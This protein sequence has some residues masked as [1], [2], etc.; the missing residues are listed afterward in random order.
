MAN[1][2]GMVLP[3]QL[4]ALSQM[5]AMAGG[6]AGQGVPPQLAQMLGQMQA[7][8][9]NPAGLAGNLMQMMAGAQQPMMAAP[10][11]TV[12]AV[13][14]Q[15]QAAPTI[16]QAAPSSATADSPSR[17]RLA[18]VSPK[19]VSNAVKMTGYA[20]KEGQKV[21]NWKK[22]YFKLTE[23][24][25][26]YHVAPGSPAK[27]HIYLKSVEDRARDLQC[28]SSSKAPIG[29]TVSVPTRTYTM[30]FQTEKQRQ[31]WYDAIKKQLDLIALRR[32]GP[33]ASA[34]APSSGPSPAIAASSAAPW[35]P[36]NMD[37]NR[38]CQLP[39]TVLGLDEPLDEL[40]QLVM[41]P[42]PGASPIIIIEGVPGSGRH[43]LMKC[44]Q[45]AIEE[46]ASQITVQH[47]GVRRIG[48]LHCATCFAA[49]F[50]PTPEL[51]ELFTIQDG[52]GI[53]TTTGSRAEAGDACAKCGSKDTQLQMFN[54]SDDELQQ[55]VDVHPSSAGE[56]LGTMLRCSLCEC[57]GIP[58]TPEG[59]CHL[60]S[61]SNGVFLVSVTGE[62]MPDVESPAWRTAIAHFMPQCAA[63]PVQSVPILLTPSLARQLLKARNTASLA[64]SM[65]SLPMISA[66]HNGFLGVG[67]YRTGLLK[68][69]T[70][71]LNEA[72]NQPDLPDLLQDMPTARAQLSQAIAHCHQATRGKIVIA[73]GGLGL[74]D[75]GRG[76]DDVLLNRPS[77]LAPCL[78][79]I[80]EMDP[81]TSA[82]MQALAKNKGISTHVISIPTDPSRTRALL[83]IYLRD[84]SKNSDMS[85]PAPTVA[86]CEGAKIPP[87]PLQLRLVAWATFH[88][89]DLK[90]V[91]LPSLLTAAFETIETRFEAI[92]K[93]ALQYI[94]KARHVPFSKEAFADVLA[95]I[96][97]LD[98]SVIK[99]KMNEL[100][101]LLRGAILC[102][103]RSASGN[104]V[105]IHP[106][107]YLAAK[108]R[109]VQTA[110]QRRELAC[111]VAKAIQASSRQHQLLEIYLL[112]SL[113]FEAG[114][115]EELVALV[116]DWTWIQNQANK[117]FPLAIIEA[118]DL[119][120][121]N[122]AKFPDTDME[123][124]AFRR[125]FSMKNLKS[126]GDPTL[127]RTVI[128]EFS[129][130]RPSALALKAMCG[131]ELD[132]SDIPSKIVRIFTSSTFDD[133]KVERD[134]LMAR[135]YPYIRER[136]KQMGLEFQVV[137][138]RWGIR[139]ESTSDHATST[140]CM[141]ELRQCQEVSLGLN[142]VTFLSQRYGYR[143]FP[144]V[145]EVA[146][147]ERLRPAVIDSAAQAYLDRWFVRDDNVVPASYVLLPI[148][149]HLP[150]YLSSDGDKRRKARGDWWSAFES[151]ALGLRQ[152]A[153][154]VLVGD[155]DHEQFLRQQFIFSVTE[156]EIRRGIL[157]VP[158]DE[159]WEKCYWFKRNIVDLDSAVKSG[160]KVS[161]KFTDLTW[162][163]PER[164]P[165]AA[166]L[167]EKLRGAEL[168]QS[169]RDD[170]ITEYD[171]NYVAEKGIDYEQQEHKVYIDK[172]VD[173]FNNLLIS[174]SEAAL[175]AQ[176]ANLSGDH[177]LEALL[178]ESTWLAGFKTAL[179]A[180]DA[181]EKQ[182][183]E[184]LTSTSPLPFVL[185]G[186]SGSGKS[187]LCAK[188][189]VSA[190]Q[191][192]PNQLVLVVRRCGS[193]AVSI[194]TFALVRSLYQQVAS[195][196]GLPVASPDKFHELGAAFKRLLTT[197]SAS[198]N[199]ILI[200]DGMD[201]LHDYRELSLWL[202]LQLPA[203][204]KVLVTCATENQHAA[205][206]LLRH[207]YGQSGFE[208]NVCTIP[209]LSPEQGAAVLDSCLV[210]QSRRL[211]QPQREACLRPTLQVNA[212]ALDIKLASDISRKWRSFHKIDPESVPMTTKGLFNM[213]L[214]QLERTHGRMLVS[215]AL[216]Y[217]TIAA[218]GI[219]DT[220]LEDLLC[221]DDEVLNDV[222]QYWTPPQRRIPPLLVIRLRRDLTGYIASFANRV[223]I[224]VYKWA[225]AELGSIVLERYFGV[226]LEE[227]ELFPDNLDV[228]QLKTNANLRNAM[229][230]LGAR[231]DADDLYVNLPEDLQRLHALCAEYY[232][233]KWAA[234]PKPYVDK[235]GSKKEASRFV[236]NMPQILLEGFSTVNQEILYP[237]HR[238][239]VELPHHL[240]QSNQ[241]EELQA[242]LLDST[243]IT[244]MCLN[245]SDAAA[246]AERE[247]MFGQYL[248]A[249]GSTWEMFLRDAEKTYKDKV[250]RLSELDGNE[251][252]SLLGTVCALS[253]IISN[254]QL[255]ASAGWLD[256]AWD[257]I[258]RQNPHLVFGDTSREEMKALMAL[259]RGDV[260]AA[261]QAAAAV[262]TAA[263]SK[264]AV[265]AN[266]RML[267]RKFQANI[268]RRLRDHGRAVAI[269]QEALTFL[270]T[271]KCSESDMAI[272][273]SAL[274]NELA[275]CYHEVGA[276]RQAAP[277]LE[278]ALKTLVSCFGEH[279][280]QVATLMHNLGCLELELGNF[281]QAE[282]L[283]IQSIN[284]RQTELGSR[285]PEVGR[286]M[287]S[288]A[289][290]YLAV[291]NM[292]QNRYADAL[293][294]L[295]RALEICQ[296]D[297][298]SSAYID[299]LALTRMSLA[300][301]QRGMGRRQE[302]VATLR[303]A[304][305]F[306]KTLK[307][308]RDSECCGFFLEIERVVRI[309]Y[310]E[311]VAD[312]EHTLGVFLLD[313]KEFVEA[314]QLLRS[315]LAKREAV[316]GPTHP[317]TLSTTE[318]VA[319]VL[320]STGRMQ[321]S[322]PFVMRV[323][324]GQQRALFG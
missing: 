277:L 311:R 182:L 314:E 135:A 86:L 108:S 5:M 292:G 270:P 278:K 52:N 291:S 73:M 287:H 172:F 63:A 60:Q 151:M 2:P 171:V 88:D 140:I 75:A 97:G 255:H 305:A 232:S 180:S 39:S 132:P 162:G 322:E 254:F 33:N 81:D 3:G 275:Q 26:T 54:I 279:D 21:K 181:L 84:L 43:T 68:M 313:D 230:S 115:F 56:V 194:S 301:A 103:S 46:K 138:M 69:L 146:D 184:Y 202:P 217:I 207:V 304:I 216:A 191:L 50:G 107:I 167:L 154:D 239:L 200:L 22:R 61:T 173:D 19:P 143:P 252:L 179:N 201:R 64:C 266:G 41:A 72:C 7:G 240:L 111:I 74:P 102:T 51:T 233:G 30:R 203:S 251:R 214:E 222:F 144:S 129:S 242:H 164:D 198:R 183:L 4:E 119:I 237:N 106:A 18:S 28:V 189:A 160:D 258:R 37:S 300:Q 209:A 213:L 283:L 100:F 185:F 269:L 133:L 208:T 85:V 290:L 276:A 303:D 45:Q 286:A 204:C 170:L 142:F 296:L 265:N 165:E 109:Y 55:L 36:R 44:I 136:L 244:Y 57:T 62:P 188:T 176:E 134:A 82:R 6:Q 122:P 155:G 158:K 187:I 79:L 195:A 263:D 272:F 47:D 309:A 27:G 8:Q 281:A 257:E 324:A 295:E 196:T 145:I 288:L 289:S 59:L 78:Q 152:A 174:T 285:H 87:T 105:A 12:P 110:E 58:M 261:L 94:A 91:D 256:Q 161:G 212:K 89:V 104:D 90:S 226:E 25:L 16:A 197:A 321:E 80:Y 219:M 215:H 32:S 262:V 210:E 312:G 76:D 101:D 323:K 147:F 131:A 13:G 319:I 284:I 70:H 83:E 224:P 268:H 253:A 280:F 169:L 157:H 139:D 320:Q 299:D 178:I 175:K 236:A 10:A 250:L 205:A 1:Q 65:P 15:A 206:S 192:F 137:D 148:P 163:K 23:S 259:A 168:R 260:T 53:A 123:E 247:R 96:S 225:H 40:L 308:D 227:K 249:V 229:L 130:A 282:P 14:S 113:Y 24:T 98:E 121:E 211:T 42:K 166:A 317:D 31:E 153:T 11:Q 124:I 243:V 199:I 231:V 95:V 9:G 298:G 120:L 221:L 128:Q 93:A 235:D 49:Q 141:T 315:A 310:L 35:R 159:R 112:P 238:R 246:A 66:F 241:L 150:D 117:G 293:P 114:M 17:G 316:L 220:E 318:C 245:G 156:E 99:S 271:L 118:F 116:R 34:A 306:A 38:S 223:G 20:E 71:S 264:G 127:A 248:R 218:D 228:T 48:A 193:S 29:L 125:E 267:A 273:E 274:L 186:A 92:G 177:L 307:V 234:V 294:M 77:E 67:R 190:R 302:S 149:T 126:L 297:E